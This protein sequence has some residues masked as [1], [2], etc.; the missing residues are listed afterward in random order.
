MQPDQSTVSLAAGPSHS[1]T[2]CPEPEPARHDG[3]K[4]AVAIGLTYLAG[5][6][7]FDW[8]TFI[9]PFERLNI[10]PW[11]PPP[12]LSVVL[13]M[14]R[15]I[16]WTPLL[17]I[18]PLSADLIVRHLWAP[19][20]ATV[21]TDIGEACV[22]AAAVWLM[23]GPLRVSPELRS[24][25]DVVGLIIGVAT[26]SGLMSAIYVGTFFKAGFVLPERVGPLIFKYW[27]GDAIGVLV[28]APLILVH[29]RLLSDTID[30]SQLFSRQT[31]GQ[32]VGL[33]VA[34]WVVF[35]PTWA[36]GSH[37]FYVIFIPVVWVAAKRGLPGVTAF[38]AV[39]QFAVVGGVL[40]LGWDGLIVTKLQFLMLLLTATGLMLGV[41]VSEREAARQAVMRGESRLRT[42]VDMTPD[43]LLV[44]DEAGCIEV[45]NVVFERLSGVPRDRALGRPVSDFILSLVPPA[46]PQFVIRHADGT[47]V[48]VEV[49][50]A[51]L[52]IGGQRG[53]VVTA[54]DISQRQRVEENK[55]LRQ[56][57][58]ERAARAT[59]SEKLAAGLAHE[60]NQPLS[61][62]IG[63]TAICRKLVD[64]IPEAPER[65]CQQMDK[66]V[67]QAERAGAIVSRLSEFFRG[68]GVDQAVVPVHEVIAD[69][70][71]LF[72]DD[73]ARIGA[74]ID[75]AAEGETV[76]RIDR[77]Q[78]EVV[79]ANLLR[80]AIEALSE[81]PR[82]DRRI[83]VSAMRQSAQWVAVRV[84]DNGPGV[85]D[86]E[87]G[88]LFNAFVTTRP[89]GM[90]L[91]LAISQSIIASHGGRLWFEPGRPA[92]ARFLFTLPLDQ[93]GDADVD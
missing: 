63:Y 25:R 77:L 11:N 26:G 90:G 27:V 21:V 78:V 85:A 50:I 15:G 46:P 91:G 4:S 42:I 38:L 48:S 44:T 34:L 3:W 17:F 23:R 83:G 53:S 62:L 47:V 65:L 57:S 66:A 31:L 2:H 1:A 79:L 87:I 22:Y 52:T 73:A 6:I 89:H 39:T 60:L 71:A 8:L 49:S 84:E 88:N 64:S 74:R 40:L 18:A 7:L 67:A 82:Q 86:D 72:V 24:L 81:S 19:P 36:D 56:S 13:L 12:G 20:L 14:L 70:A 61:A 76:V 30:Y 35:V 10:T 55:K 68:G 16:R 5:Y 33:L 41:V 58:L 28:I 93:E 59:F 29:R 92:G 43:A 54:R 37:A 80:N 9:D 75:V 45:A 69:V 51:P 32:A